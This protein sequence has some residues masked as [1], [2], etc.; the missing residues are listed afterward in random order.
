LVLPADLVDDAAR[1]KRLLDGGSPTL[2]QLA[3]ERL[4][5]KGDYDRSVR[6]AR[7][8]YRA[9]R[10]RLVDALQRL[11][12]DCTIHGIAAGLHLLLRLPP[13]CDDRAIATAA[14]GARI[15]IEALTNYRVDRGRRDPALVLGYGRLAEASI[16]DAVRA[17][18][19]VIRDTAPG[20]D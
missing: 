16:P 11:L 5:R 6:R 1:T 10:D 9:R 8:V 7:A 2:D 19:A 4:L 17:L 14:A 15:K 20:G 12:P 18:A 3:F 13:E